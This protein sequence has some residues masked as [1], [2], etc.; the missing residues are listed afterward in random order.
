VE[1]DPTHNVIA[2]VRAESRRQDDLRRCEQKYQEAADQH[3]KEVAALRAEYASKLDAKESA[4][5]DAIRSVDQANV[6]TAAQQTLIAVN[7]LAAT[8]ARDAETLRTALTNTAATIA[9]QTAQ[10]V[11]GLT[12]RITAL[13]KAVNLGAGRGAGFSTS[14]AV[15]VA[16][17]LMLG[18]L[19]A[20]W[21]SAPASPPQVIY[22]TPPPV[23]APVLSPAR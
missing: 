17:V 4:R 21:K 20:V 12:E 23:T 9:T 8:A 16:A 11:A 19:L 22:A 10:T 6:T 13:E 3:Q 7:T 15:L 1:V 18:T 2:L 5:L 14:W